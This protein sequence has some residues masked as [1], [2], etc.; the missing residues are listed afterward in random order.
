MSRWTITWIT[1]GL[2]TFGAGCVTSPTDGSSY[3]PWQPLSLSGYARGSGEGIQVQA[4]DYCAGSWRPIATFTASTAPTTFGGDTLYAWSG[5]VTFTW[6]PQWDC[7]WQGTGGFFKYAE[8]RVREVGT[9]N[10][11]TTFDSQGV[12]CVVDLMSQGTGWLN[13]GY[14]CRGASSPLIHLS[15]NQ[16]H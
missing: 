8:L 6:I 16:I 13:A 10:V 4:M 1:L 12:S 7:L 2:L 9:G 14:Q 11:L 3:L 5:S 15:W